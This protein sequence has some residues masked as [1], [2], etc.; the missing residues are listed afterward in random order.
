M[1]FARTLPPGFKSMMVCAELKAGSI[2]KS[3]SVIFLYIM[4]CMNGELLSSS[5][6]TI[7]ESMVYLIYTGHS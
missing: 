2:R 6:E 5:V 7:E 3:K 4:D 1:V